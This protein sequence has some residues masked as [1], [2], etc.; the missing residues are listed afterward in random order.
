MTSTYNSDTCDYTAV[1]SVEVKPNH[2]VCTTNPEGPSGVTSYQIE[3]TADSGIVV[4]NWDDADCGAST[5]SRPSSNYVVAAQECLQKDQ[6]DGTTAYVTS[7]CVNTFPSAPTSPPAPAPTTRFVEGWFVQETF[8]S[9]NCS[10]DLD[11]RET[12]SVGLCRRDYD[13]YIGLLRYVEGYDKQGAVAAK[14][15]GK[16]KGGMG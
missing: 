2:G 15:G 4:Y 3:C 12:W 10:G 14:P 13:P 6:A 8:G 7:N 11:K 1:V 5:Q 9:D 16:G